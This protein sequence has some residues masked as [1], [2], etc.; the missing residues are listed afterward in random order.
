LLNLADVVAPSRVN[1]PGAR[2]VLWAQGCSIRCRGCHNPHTWAPEPRRVCTVEAAVAW[3]KRFPGLRGVTLSGGEPFE[4]AL[5]FAALCRAL[6]AEGADVVAFSGLTRR[7][8]EADARP[9]ARA[10]LAEVDLLVDGPYVAER[11]ARLPLR[12]SENQSLHFLTGRIRPEEVTGLCAVEWIGRGPR[13]TVTGFSLR[14][15]THPSA[16]RRA[17]GAP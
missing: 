15:L 10:L 16:S 17:R 14:T 6:R 13:A 5:A 4:Q 7:E 1:G 3:V 8:I 11:A 12:G 2:A 9:S